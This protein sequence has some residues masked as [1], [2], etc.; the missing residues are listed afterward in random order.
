MLVKKELKKNHSSLILAFFHRTI[1]MVYFY[2][3][4]LYRKKK[5]G[6][7]YMYLNQCKVSESVTKLHFKVSV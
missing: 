6:I 2:Y 3:I 1:I 4:E 5:F 7:S